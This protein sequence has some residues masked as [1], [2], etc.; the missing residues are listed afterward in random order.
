MK[1]EQAYEIEGKT[2]WQFSRRTSSSGLL[3]G[4]D[5]SLSVSAD[6]LPSPRTERDIERAKFLS[7]SYGSGSSSNLLATSSSTL[8]ISP[9]SSGKT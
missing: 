3:S 6:R 8:P 4:W 5:R 2:Q 9:S 1:I 7:K